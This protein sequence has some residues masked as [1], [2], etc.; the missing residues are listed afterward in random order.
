MT[1]YNDG[2]IRSLCIKL[3]QMIV[4]VKHFHINKRLFFKVID[5]KLLKKYTKIWEKVSSL[6]NIEFN[7]EPVYGDND[8]YK[9]TKIKLYGSKVNTNF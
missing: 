2:V 5:N 8:E 3:P 4:Y 9:K 6:I 1:A 7:S